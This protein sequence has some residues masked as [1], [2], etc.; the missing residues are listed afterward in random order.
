MEQAVSAK[1][2]LLQIGTPRPFGPN[3]VPSSMGR[4]QTADRV[5]V[6]ALGFEGDRV[7]DPV[8]HGGPDKAVH[9]YP[10]A[11][12][13][14]WR[15][16]LPKTAA[17][18]VDGSFGENLTLNH[19]T[20]RDICIGDVF[21]C[22]PVRLQVTQARQPCWKLNIRFDR[23]DM[24]RLVQDTG[25][26]GWYFRVLEPG[27]IGA[28]DTLKLVQ[29]PNPDWPLD[30]VWRLL[31]REAPD[32]V[33]LQAFAALEGLSASWQRLAARR[34]ETLNVEDWSPRLDG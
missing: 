9:A 17:L 29:R 21:A 5:A 23:R 25:R 7:G 6:R 22:G 34:L 28:G 33:T 27:D 15:R 18:L 26:T 12:Y 16:D 3:G 11:H 30:R 1:V 10:R 2:A 31:Y 20:E 8:F 32:A 4:A 19:L 14:D 13:V 24:S